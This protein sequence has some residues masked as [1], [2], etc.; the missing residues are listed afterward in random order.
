MDDVELAR[1]TYSREKRTD[2]DNAFKFVAGYIK[3]NAFIHSGYFYSASSSPL[4]LRGADIVTKFH[5]EASQW[6]NYID[7]GV[8]LRMNRLRDKFTELT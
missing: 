5:A 2:Y 7:G 8:I 4:L 1:L 6:C 3:D